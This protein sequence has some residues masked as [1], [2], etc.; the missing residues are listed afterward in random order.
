[1]KVTVLPFGGL[2]NRMRVMNSAI[3]FC[4]DN[5][6]SHF[7]LI[8][9][10]KAELNAPYELIFNNAGFPIKLLKGFIY[11]LFLL[12]V[13]HIYV[14]RYESV[15][16]FVL[17]FFYDCILFDS[18]IRE[19]NYDQL[20][21]EAMHK[22]NV[23]IATCFALKGVE[24]FDNFRP[25]QSVVHLLETYDLPESYFGVHIRRQDHMD[26][27]KESPEEKFLEIIE[28]QLLLKPGL[29][30]FLATDDKGVKV[31]F[32]QFFPDQLI[33]K[34]IP[35]RRDSPEA[36]IAALAD[37]YAL[38]GAELIICN[39]KSSFAETALRIGK[40]KEVVTV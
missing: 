5:G 29:P 6:V 34:D 32:Q 37:I 3:D 27:I 10:Q 35:L 4:K 19:K 14:N 8:W 33:T 28:K 26:I 13:K 16:R 15:Y 21:E 9:L 24:N 23:L 11:V 22:K 18:D 20:S 30:F 2:G 31:R 38:S 12:F 17:G 40:T 1:M 7:H 36:I 25:S 39:R